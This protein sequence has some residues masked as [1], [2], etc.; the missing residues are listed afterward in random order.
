MFRFRTRRAFTL[1]ELLVVI[2]IIAILIGLLLPAVQKVREAAARIK[3]ANSLKQAGLGLHNHHDANMIF[4]PGLG[5]MNDAAVVTSANFSTPTVPQNLRVRTWCHAVL[6]Y[7]E[8]DALYK[9]LALCP[10]Y[11]TGGVH[12]ISIDPKPSGNAVPMFTCASDPRGY[13]RA[14][15]GSGISTSPEQT[16]TNYAAVGGV[17]QYE[18]NWPKAHGI[19]YWRSKTRISDVTDGTSNTLLI[20]E[21]PWAHVIHYGWWMSWH[22]VGTFSSLKA[23]ELDTIQ[24]MAMTG[25]SDDEFVTSDTGTPCPYTPTRTPNN[26]YTGSP[27]ADQIANLYG[28][29][30]HQNPCDFNHFWSHHTGGANFVL[31][32]G[33]VRFISYSAKSVMNAMSTRAMGEVT[34]GQG[35]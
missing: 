4:P 19:M 25:E 11:N 32:D 7:I 34:D 29:G 20:G 16:F 12:G 1:I 23:W 28:P 10:G 26:R 6:P 2:A 24:Y 3:C 22:S 8:Q 15:A 13:V 33:S 31:G 30:R 35:N 17:D 18:P 5:A 21:R 9:Q 14:P 27:A